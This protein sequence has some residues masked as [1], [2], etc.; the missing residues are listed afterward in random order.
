MDDYDANVVTLIVLHVIRPLLSKFVR[1]T[2][3]N[4]ITI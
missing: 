3:R 4:C 1:N 2:F